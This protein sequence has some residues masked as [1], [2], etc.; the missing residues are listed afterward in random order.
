[1]SEL[2]RLRRSRAAAS[3][4]ARLPHFVTAGME[5]GALMFSA[6]MAQISGLR[7]TDASRAAFLNQLSTVFVPL[8]A[9]A[10]GTEALTTKVGAG[11]VCALAGV[12]LL[13]IG[14]GVSGAAAEVARPW[15]GDILE[16]LAAVISTMYLLRVSYHAQ[17]TMGK[18][19]ALVAVKVVTQACLSLLWAGGEW[20]VRKLR[21]ELGASVAAAATTT[22]VAGKWTMFS[23]AMNVGLVL[24]AGIVVGAGTSW[25]QT[26]GQSCVPAG[27]AAILNA[28]AP[29]W[30]S[31]I[32]MLF[33]GERMGR[34][35]VAGAGL[36]L[37]GT[38]VSGTG[39]KE[40]EA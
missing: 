14:S 6:N 38:V 35:G 29:L 33:L 30:T 13:T 27:E 12:G 8:T 20:M 40:K 1:M 7:F 5:L 9:A 36:I 19:G 24:W 10:V 22:A 39:E 18:A 26:R 16:V 31:V 25:M 17:R 2:F 15:L 28:A 32:A 21:G 3:G 34:I 37:A 11:A 23:L 4:S